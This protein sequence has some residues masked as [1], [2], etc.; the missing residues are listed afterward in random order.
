MKVVGATNIMTGNDGDKGSSSVRAS[1]LYATKRIGSD[2]SG[3]TVTIASGLDTSVDTS[4][5]ASPELDISI[6]HRLASCHVN[7]VDVEMSD[8][9]LLAS[10]DVLADKLATNPYN[11]S[12]KSAAMDVCFSLQYGPSPASGSSV[13]AASVP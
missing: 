9:T 5:V 13:Q 10:E 11:S 12:V 6:R 2:S 4:G 7:D 3:R 8:G 1:W